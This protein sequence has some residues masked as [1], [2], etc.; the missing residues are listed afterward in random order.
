MSQP[1]PLL[2]KKCLDQCCGS[3][4]SDPSFHLV[5]GFKASMP[6]L[7]ASTALHGS[8]F[9]DSHLNLLHKM[10]RIRI[11]RLKMMGIHT[12]PVSDP[13]LLTPVT[14]LIHSNGPLMRM[15]C[16]IDTVLYLLF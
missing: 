6:P 2:Y 9:A 3:A 10:M 12:N 11:R 5:S 7:L 14:I 15:P 4:D 16:L 8:N 13:Q 1:C